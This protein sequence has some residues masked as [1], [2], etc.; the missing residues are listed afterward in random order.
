MAGA[1]VDYHRSSTFATEGT[2]T[3]LLFLYGGSEV[4]MSALCRKKS[5]K[6]SDFQ[7]PVPLDSG[8]IHDPGAQSFPFSAE[9]TGAYPLCRSTVQH[10]CG[11]SAGFY[12][13]ATCRQCSLHYILS[14]RLV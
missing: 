5:G 7:S 8:E 3:R 13:L 14:C 12:D 9:C 2:D 11:V 10:V 6:M 1:P 4:K